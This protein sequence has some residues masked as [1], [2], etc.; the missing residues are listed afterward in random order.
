MPKPL[1][2]ALRKSAWLL[3]I[4]LLFINSDLG[5]YRKPMISESMPTGGIDAKNLAVVINDNDPFSLEIGA[6]YVKK[7]LIPSSQVIHLSL[8]VGVSE[9]PVSQFRWILRDVNLSL[10]HI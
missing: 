7:R 9:I 3:L 2:Y 10:I 6:L 1:K 8:P 5:L 4:G